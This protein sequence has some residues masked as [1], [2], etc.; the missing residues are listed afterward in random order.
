M[1]NGNVPVYFLSDSSRARGTR[2]REN[3]R[4]PVTILVNTDERIR[5]QMPDAHRLD[6]R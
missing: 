2:L 5:C 3:L 1:K 6:T 4:Q